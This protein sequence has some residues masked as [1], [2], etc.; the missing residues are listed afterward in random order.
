[1]RI[2]PEEPA[3]AMAVRAVNEAAF[4]SG[5]EA[6][7]V[8]KLRAQSDSLV[9]LVAELDG[10][11][12]G[13]IVFSPVSIEGHRGVR[14]MGLGPMAV[15]PNHQRQGIGSKLARAGLEQC[16][17]RGISAVVVLGH[18]EYYPRFGFEPASRFG[19]TSQYDVPDDVFML[20]ELESGS[21]HGVS[22]R[23]MYSDAFAGA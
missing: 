23:A 21:L 12:V 17:T 18:S 7:I 15:L 11:V 1:M 5:V 16:R 14:M 2:R 3:D 22:G 4:G 8:E 20:V 13:H 6:E 10:V 9:S 19:I